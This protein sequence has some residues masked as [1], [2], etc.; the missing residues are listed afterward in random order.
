[1]NRRGWVQLASQRLPI[2]LQHLVQVVKEPRM[3]AVRKVQLP[4]P[5]K[6]PKVEIPLLNMAPTALLHV[7]GAD[8]GGFDGKVS[9]NEG[10]LYSPRTL[11]CWSSSNGHHTANRGD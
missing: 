5:V 7:V 6:C 3:P 8:V 4:Q 2:T 9:L 10:Y 11:L 1:M